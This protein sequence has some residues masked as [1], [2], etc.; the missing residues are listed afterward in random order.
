VTEHI[1]FLIYIFL[2]IFSTIGHGVIFSNLIS[3]ELLSKNIAY[4]GIIGFFS[5]S[6][7]SLISSYF[8]AHNYIHNAI[9]HTVGIIGFILFIKKNKK[10]FEDFKN[11]TILIL[12]FLI[13][14]YVYK[15]HDDFP[16][17][18]LT[19][20][21]NLS[22]NRFIIGTGIFS[23]GFR[24]FSSIFYYH[25]ILYMP[26]IKYFLFHI[27]P[28]Y[29][30][31]FFNFIVIK[32]IFENYKN[33]QINFL[34]YFSLLS[35]IFVNIAFYRIGEHGTDRSAMILLLLIFYYYF[36]LLNFEKSEE[37]ISTNLNFILILIF[38]A[39]SMKAIYYMY[40][41]LIPV[42][43][44]KKKYFQKFFKKKNILIIFILSLSFFG[45]LTTNYFNT[46]C[47]LYPAEKTCIG[48][49][50]WSIPSKEVKRMNIHYEWWAKAGGGPGYK[51]EIKREIYIKNFVW[52]ENWI[53]RHFFNKVS[54]TLFGIILICLIVYLSFRGFSKKKMFNRINSIGL[55]SYLFPLIFLLEWFLKHPAMRYGGYVLIA[56]P[57]FI[58]TSSLLEKFNLNK[59]KIYS[60]TLVFLLIAI[61][62]F[63]GR[64]IIRLNKEFDIYKY[65][66]LSSPYF[67]IEKNISDTIID[68]GN[69]KVYSPPPGKMCWSSKT[70][71]SYA[72][73]IKVKEFFGLKVVYRDDW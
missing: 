70:P 59:K 33:K 66:I 56:L 37:K 2:F 52:L 28:L 25:S 41:I 31:I 6:L 49:A 47:F 42:I 45:N 60:T 3:K 65:N 15:N 32:N 43:L 57:F 54:D 14:A 35:L 19:Y 71:C 8:F 72:R 44:F 24:T 17:Y 12:I 21:L 18:H 13:A 67:F 50:E 48:K 68:L 5:L 63:V 22:E 29:I 9:I 4:Q 26:F 11:L 46:G 30:L 20:S 64:N 40:L 38:L 51:S 62:V 53:K 7:I 58:Y 10:N 27:G 39:S 73:N 23:H 1:I 55:S 61:I 36:Q 34:Y 69:F 16:Y